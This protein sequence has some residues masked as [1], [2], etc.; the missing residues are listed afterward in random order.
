[1]DMQFEILAVRRL[2]GP[3]GPIDIHLGFPTREGQDFICRYF[4]VGFGSDKIRHA[5][6][7]DGIQA[8]FMALRSIATDLYTSQDWKKGNITWEGGVKC[9]DLGLPLPDSIADILHQN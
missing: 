2:N 8:L 7:A 5:Y 1:M 9:G 6:G 3:H 4:L